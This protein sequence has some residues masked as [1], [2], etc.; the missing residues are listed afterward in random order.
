MELFEVH[1]IDVNGNSTVETDIREALDRWRS[2]NGERL[3]INIE[4]VVFKLLRIY[5]HSKMEEIVL[6][7]LSE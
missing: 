1:T 2:D 3:R 6:C 7:D 5:D 4:G